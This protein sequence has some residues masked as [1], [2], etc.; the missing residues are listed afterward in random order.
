MDARLRFPWRVRLCNRD[1]GYLR[2]AL[3]TI[4]E[5]QRHRHDV[6]P[7]SPPELL[8]EQGKEKS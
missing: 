1:D 7:S 3:L 5:K 4:V 6:G 2:G 8:G